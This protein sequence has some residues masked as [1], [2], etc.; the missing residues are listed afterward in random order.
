MSGAMFTPCVT[1]AVWGFPL[2]PT[3]GWVAVPLPDV[4]GSPPLLWSNLYVQSHLAKL[5]PGL[6]NPTLNQGTSGLM[7]FSTAQGTNH[8]AALKLF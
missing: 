6:G 4:L 2:R 1:G 8:V 3:C 5:S 7:L